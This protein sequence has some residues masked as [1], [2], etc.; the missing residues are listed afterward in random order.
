MENH[1]LGKLRDLVRRYTHADEKDCVERL[2]KISSLTD[3]QR[4]NVITQGQSLVEA[5]RENLLEVGTLDLFL[6][7]Y[8]LSSKEGVALMCLAESLLRIPDSDTA[9]ELIAEKILSGNW[10]EHRG[11][12]ESLFVN[13]S[14]WGLMLTG[15]VVKLDS[16]LELDPK[17]WL[18]GLVNKLGEPA[19]RS[20]I[21]QAMKI[22]GQQYVLGQTVGEALKRYE[23]EYVEGTRISIDMLGEGARTMGSADNYFRKYIQAIREIGHQETQTDV[24]EANGISVKLSALHPRY[25]FKQK[26]RVISELLPRLNVLAK[27][28]RTFGIGFTLDA[29]EA[30]RLDLSLDVFEALLCDPNLQNW[31]G[32]GLALQAYN[33]RAPYIVDWLIELAR[34]TG[35]RIMVR[36]VK[37]AYWDS[38]IK[39]AQENG[40]SDYPVYTRKA[41]TDLS[42]QV[43]AQKLLQA[44]DVIYPQFA[45]HN[46]QTVALIL[47]LGQGKMFEFQR[48][49][50]MGK[51][52][53]AELAK[54]GASIPLRVYAPVGDHKDL[55][56]YLVRRLLEN[57]ANSSFVN[58]FLD[59]N[60]PI[61]NMIGD[62][63]A[64]VASNT[65]RRHKSIPLPKD[66]S[67]FAG[68]CRPNTLGVDL[69]NAITADK[70]IRNIESTAKEYPSTGSTEIEKGD[71][72]KDSGLNNT[73]KIA[74]TCPADLNRVIGYYCEATQEDA[75]NALTKADLAQPDWNRLGGCKRADIMERAAG[76]FETRMTD[77]ISLIVYEGG[78]TIDDAVSEVREAADF[79]RYYALQ[80]RNL[81][82]SYIKVSN[83]YGKKSEERL[84]GRGVVFCI[85]P[86]N[87]PLA[88]FTGQ[89]AAA[90]AAGNAVVAK[91]ANQTPL[92]ASLAVQLLLEAGVPNDV[93]QI[94]TGDGKRLGDIFN[95]DERVKCIAFTGSTA[96][97]QKIYKMTLE[98]PGELP[99]LIA[100]TGGQNCMIVDSSSL[101][102]QVVDDAIRSAFRSA[103]QR[104]SA[105]RVM[106]VQEEIADTVIDMLKGAMQEL[107][108]GMPCQLATDVGPV[109]DEAAICNL[110]Q[111]IENMKREAIL[112]FSCLLPAELE[113]GSFVAPHLFE[114]NSIKQ[115]PGEIFGPILHVIRFRKEK[116]KDALTDINS[117][118]FGLTLGIHSRVESF[119][120]EVINHTR[121]GNNYVNRNMVGAVVGI[122]PFGGIG[123]SGTGPKAGGPNYVVRFA[124]TAVSGKGERESQFA[125]DNLSLEDVNAH[126]LF[127]KEVE[128]LEALLVRMQDASFGWNLNGG[129]YRASLL[130]IAA[131]KFEK[132]RP[133][134][135]SATALCRYYAN[136]AREKFQIPLVLPG[137]TGETNELKLEGRG[138]FLCIT[139]DRS[140]IADFI[141][142]VVAALAAGNVVIATPATYFSDQAKDVVN[143]LLS[144]GISSDVLHL[145]P[146]AAVCAELLCDYRLAGIAVRGGNKTLRSVRLGLSQRDA[147]IIPLI[148]DIGSSH[149]ITRFAI[150]KTKTVNIVA[151]S[152]NTCLLNL[153][154]N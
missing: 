129:N 1:Q 2:L 133:H 23:K 150:E 92:I 108:V 24:I 141:E 67:S 36:L 35:Q 75:E 52:L 113:S 6:Q 85:S 148:T 55:L 19:V 18:Q 14:T 57:G 87:F 71:V 134:L 43:C 20:A 123:L 25:E 131:H 102:E 115:L 128:P 17:N 112:H 94:I 119:A 38:E 114:L 78:R 97:A 44:Q 64:D 4:Q 110:Q 79:L 50:G 111:H 120:D 147:N 66:I 7:E 39:F 127:E 46:A 139:S 16:N 93:L 135:S 9:D 154:E 65:Y 37:G 41:N 104:C 29:E 149:F 63:E 58:R 12:S 31:H 109:I 8:S 84:H 151:T 72:V 82:K 103:G 60:T 51:L 53:Y 34:D 101:P 45:T 77:L 32:L 122:N 138:V 73:G 124:K 33:K 13:A 70:L 62:I 49:H 40:Y 56:P 22:M 28:A 83:P 95:V 26:S 30:N 61:A 107:N 81:F 5:C 100:E 125:S 143:T 145:M 54:Q 42:Y 105:L 88:I 21:R 132:E 121:V 137:P 130:E 76:L 118:G 48:L 140:G 68:E 90:L 153:G 117:T 69:D 89:I 15:R 11:H 10:T 144:A 91:P 116:L 146:S 98:R 3:S 96:V 59:R 86:W 152:G 47:T 142:L 74:I 99:I 106:Y 80:A 27:E 136:Q 126:T